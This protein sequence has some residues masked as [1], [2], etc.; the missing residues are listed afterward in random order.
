MIEVTSVAKPDAGATIWSGKARI[1]KRNLEWFYRPRGWLHVREQDP[2]IPRCW[3][4]IE[5]PDGAR[6]VVLRAVRKAKRSPGKTS[7]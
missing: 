1:G 4:N 3:V 7:K 5:T 2:G 6:E